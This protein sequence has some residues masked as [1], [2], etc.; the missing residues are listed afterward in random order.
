MSCGCQSLY[1]TCNGCT[2]C[3][4]CPETAPPALPTCPNPEPCD[5]VIDSQCVVYTGASLTCIG[6]TTPQTPP[7]RLQTILTNIN[8][9]MCNAGVGTTFVGNTNCIS[10]SGTGLSGSPILAT[11]ILDSIATNILGCTSSGLKVVLNYQNA[12]CITLAGS[13]TLASPLTASLT[14][15]TGLQCISGTISTT[16]S[17]T[18]SNG[19]TS[20]TV[21]A[22][23]TVKL[24][25]DLTQNTSVNLTASNYTLS[26]TGLNGDVL[27]MANSGTTFFYTEGLSANNYFT[28]FTQV[29]QGINLIG[30]QYTNVTSA[31]YNAISTIGINPFV[32]TSF[33]GSYY[34]IG[35]AVLT[36]QSA[37]Y[38]T[39]LGRTRAEAF[40]IENESVNRTI[41]SSTLISGKKYIITAAGGTF[42]SS[43]AS[44]NTVGTIFTANSTPPVWGS[45]AVQTYGSIKDTVAPWYSELTRTGLNIVGT[46][47]TSVITPTSGVNDFGYISVATA[48]YTEQQIYSSAERAGLGYRSQTTFVQQCGLTTLD[49]KLV[50]TGVNVPGALTGGTAP[51]NN[52]Y[53]SYTTW[54]NNPNATT[55]GTMATISPIV[56]F[57]GITGTFAVNGGLTKIGVNTSTPTAQL[58]IIGPNTAASLRIRT[59]FTPA[60]TAAAGN[61]GDISWDLTYLY[62]YT[63]AGWKRT[64]ALSTF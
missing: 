55:Q 17:I 18:A 8:T 24:G 64:A 51:E 3:N 12:G 43:G 27:T 53:T 41:G 21:G 9:A 4:C 62:V 1:S 48:Q 23:T 42:T 36:Q 20:A 39:T 54:F 14:L 25:G 15:G 45:G 37:I 13:G 30:D 11:P 60:N 31:G 38:S 19:L 34:P 46:I 29:D 10:L 52:Q 5:S 47:D 28:R 61:L 56:Y 44:A 57:T 2:P 26:V 16:T 6:I 35:T 49:Q 59:A 50:K 32:G 58:D 7:V 40:N 33:M 63:S 22:A